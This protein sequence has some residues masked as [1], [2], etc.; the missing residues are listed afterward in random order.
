MFEAH[1]LRILVGKNPELDYGKANFKVVESSLGWAAERWRA[2]GNTTRARELDLLRAN[3]G[4][5]TPLAVA[6]NHPTIDEL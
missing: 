1:A 3:L 2:A 5:V 4:A 6:K